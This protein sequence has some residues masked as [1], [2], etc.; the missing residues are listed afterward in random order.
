MHDDQT[1]RWDQP[2]D[3]A[4]VVAVHDVVRSQPTAVVVQ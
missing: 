3:D 1:L 2:V 4:L